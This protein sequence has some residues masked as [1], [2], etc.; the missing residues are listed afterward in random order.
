MTSRSLGE[1][2]TT[3]RTLPDSSRSFYAPGP[4]VRQAGDSSVAVTRRHAPDKAEVAEQLGAARRRTLDLT[5]AL[6]DDDLCRQHS[7]LDVAARLGPRPRRQL[8]GPVAARRRRRRRRGSAGPRRPVRRVPPPARRA[9]LRP[10]APV[11]G[12]RRAYIATRARAGARRSRRAPTLDDER[13]LPPRRL[14]LRD[15]HPARAPARRDDAGHAAAHGRARATCFGGRSPAAG[16]LR[17]PEAEV[18][19]ARRRV[20]DGHRPRSV[21]LRQRAAGPRRST[22][23]RSPST[24]RR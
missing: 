7:P 22:S 11:A 6:D 4:P 12:G 1:T 21:G 23:R 2:T 3:F 5:G 15:G 18:Q 9:P 19:R 10:A 13:P 16:G 24:P 20:H 8:R 17:P 14:R